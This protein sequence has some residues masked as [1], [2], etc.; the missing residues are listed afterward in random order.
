MVSRGTNSP[1]KVSISYL[2]HLSVNQDGKSPEGAGNIKLYYTVM[3]IQCHNTI[4]HYISDIRN[5]AFCHC[6][7]IIP[8]DVKTPLI[9]RTS[10]A[11]KGYSYYKYVHGYLDNWS[12][13]TEIPHKYNAKLIYVIF[14]ISVIDF[15]VPYS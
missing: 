13:T 9:I 3:H 12:R 10:S 4:D 11:E 15:I 1:V 7:T 5:S 2:F 6:I 8:N 14:C